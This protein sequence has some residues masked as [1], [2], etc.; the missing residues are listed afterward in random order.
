MG[1]PKER[2]NSSLC[3]HNR[4]MF[5]KYQFP[6]KQ[7]RFPMAKFIFK[8]MLTFKVDITK[9]GKKVSLT[10][11]C[12]V[13]NFY[14]KIKA[15]HL[16]FSCSAWGG[17]LIPKKEKNN[18][19]EKNLILYDQFSILKQSYQLLVVQLQGQIETCFLERVEET[20]G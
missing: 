2:V 19:L 20:S 5:N 6:V 8:R 11:A 16:V 3:L 14:S 4:S 13:C 15:A 7:H 17:L 10:Q 1:T 12:R 9:G 18:S